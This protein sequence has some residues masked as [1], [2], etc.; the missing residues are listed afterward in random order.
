[1]VAVQVRRAGLY[2]AEPM[3]QGTPATKPHLPHRYGGQTGLLPA[4]L[5]KEEALGVLLSG[6]AL[7]GGEAATGA[8]G[9]QEYSKAYVIPPTVPARPTPSTIQSRCC[10]ITRRALGCHPGRQARQECGAV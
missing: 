5:L 6:P 1:M 3:G 9:S 2:P 4:V 8:L 10:T 7:H